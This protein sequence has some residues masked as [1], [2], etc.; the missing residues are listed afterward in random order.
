MIALV[1]R[2]VCAAADE[3]IRRSFPK[4]RVGNRSSD[5]ALRTN[6]RSD[7]MDRLIEAMSSNADVNK[8]VAAS[9][10]VMVGKQDAIL[11]AF[12]LTQIQQKETN[13]KVDTVLKRLSF[14]PEGA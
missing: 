3:A 9:L 8:E 12:K 14:R 4:R 5:D 1:W 13:A 7:W 10:A 2:A 6:E 11:E